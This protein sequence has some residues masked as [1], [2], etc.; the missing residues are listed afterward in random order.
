MCGGGGTTLSS[1]SREE[2]DSVLFVR[3]IRSFCYVHADILA[4]RILACGGRGEACMLATRG[5]VQ[6]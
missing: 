3:E 6:C 2:M 1:R 4:V 5:G